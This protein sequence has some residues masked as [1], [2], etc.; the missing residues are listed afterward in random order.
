MQTLAFA[1][2]WWLP[3]CG[4]GLSYDSFSYGAAEG[5]AREQGFVSGITS[6][7]DVPVHV[8]M[9]CFELGLDWGHQQA[10][11]GGSQCERSYVEGRQNGLLQ[12]NTRD[13]NACSEIGY[14]AG[15][16]MLAHYARS[17]QPNKVP[18]GQGRECVR[19]YERGLSGDHS[20]TPAQN[21]LIACFQ[22]GVWDSN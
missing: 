3:Y 12:N 1:L 21:I 10:R 20:G 7:I 2:A 13:G 14:Q 18:D 4:L 9:T 22:A 19:Q 11:A 15:S 16:A 6:G 8:D 5:A 17:N